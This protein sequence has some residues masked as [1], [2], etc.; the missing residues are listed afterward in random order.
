LPI[1][2]VDA[3]DLYDALRTQFKECADV[4]FY[5]KYPVKKDNLV[6]G[7]EATHQAA[8]EIWQLTGYRFT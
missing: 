5:G 4:K 1:D 6:D 7:N 2:Y 3:E 8:R